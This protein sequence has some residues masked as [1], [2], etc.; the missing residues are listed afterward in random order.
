MIYKY[1]EPNFKYA[2]LDMIS[3]DIVHPS[4]CWG[5]MVNYNYGVFGIG[6]C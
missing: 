3:Q 5:I 2:W 6:E 4:E 1:G